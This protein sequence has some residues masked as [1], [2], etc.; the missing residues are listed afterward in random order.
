MTKA[1][2]QA[3]IGAMATGGVGTIPQSELRLSRGKPKGAVGDF[4]WSP[5][6]VLA[7]YDEEEAFGS[8]RQATT[9]CR[10]ETSGMLPAQ[11][12]PPARCRAVL[13]FP[14]SGPRG[15]FSSTGKRR[16][17]HYAAAGREVAAKRAL[18]LEW[19]RGPTSM[20]GAAALDL[21][22]GLALAEDG[23]AVE[24]NKKKGKYAIETGILGKCR[25]LPPGEGR[26]KG[27]DI[28]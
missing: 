8:A 9:L 12:Q 26:R 14:P 22:S 19:R 2:Q 11:R 23:Q 21:A 1:L 28:F 7:T 6:I 25:R 20:W 4:T 18:E 5:A 13:M 24:T 3:I 10:S 15:R 16:H 27:S 17:I